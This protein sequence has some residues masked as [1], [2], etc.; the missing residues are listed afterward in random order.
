M[1]IGPVLGHTEPLVELES[2]S[3][4][5]YSHFFNVEA[6]NYSLEKLFENAYLF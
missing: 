3:S 4:L 1:L 2:A 6:V 5:L